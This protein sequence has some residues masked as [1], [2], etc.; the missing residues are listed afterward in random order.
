MIVQ[1]N[2]HDVF[3]GRVKFPTGGIVRDPLRR[4]IRCDSGTNSIV[5]MEEQTSG[6]V[7]R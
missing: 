5:W 2:N 7:Q 1:L 3:R 4:L 6:F